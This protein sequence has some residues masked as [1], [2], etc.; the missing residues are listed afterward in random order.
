LSKDLQADKITLMPKAIDR[1]LRSPG[2][3][4][5]LISL[6][7]LVSIMGTV[8]MS[9]LEQTA[10]G[11][12]LVPAFQFLG[13]EQMYRTTWFM[14]LLAFLTLV[15]SYCSLRRLP[16]VI[17]TFRHSGQ[18][19]AQGGSPLIEVLAGHKNPLE[20][21]RQ[22]IVSP[23]LTKGYRVRRNHEMAN[24][25]LLFEKGRAGVIGPLI[26]HM[27][28]L[29][30][31]IG[32][33]VT[34]TFGIINDIDL[35]E[36]EIYSLGDSGMKLKLE[37]FSIITHPSAKEPEEYVSTLMVTD[38][39]QPPSW[40]MLRVNSPLRLSGF[41]LYQMRYR[42]EVR[43]VSLGVFKPGTREP[44]GL[45]KLVPGERAKLPGYDLEV[46]LETIVPDF[47]IDPEG[48]V[49]SRSQYYVNPAAF[50]SAYR[51]GV[52]EPLW[53]GWA[54]KGTFPPHSSDA[55]FEFT[56]ERLSLKYYSG[57][58]IVNDPGT[59]IV[60]LGFGLLVVGSVISCY[61]FRRVIRVEFGKGP[62]GDG[63][64]T[65]TG[66]SWK[67]Q[68][69]FAYEWNGLVRQIRRAIEE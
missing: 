9:A 42:A 12:I 5:T 11:K 20:N 69:D 52:N 34:H 35:G 38:A 39:N 17:R 32:G 28:L 14:S 41:N 15:M 13:A 2:L 45:V 65:L 19:L 24:D 16:S 31:F 22:K 23:L 27:G 7:G 43:F 36:G 1:W 30:V 21:L 50:V 8:P 53:S 54:F 55:P 47:A 51:P 56:V 18:M 46:E 33:L 3:T 67:N 40:H 4:I 60:Y 61:M 59:P 62:D 66:Q 68:P 58:K 48:N 64:L 63:T 49:H 37:K 29:I 26:V 25:N 44:A 6:I 10:A 57:I